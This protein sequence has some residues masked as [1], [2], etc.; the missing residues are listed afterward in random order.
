MNASAGLCT[1]T[2]EVGD[3]R[4]LAPAATCQEI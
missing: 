4:A 3:V 1:R 2:V